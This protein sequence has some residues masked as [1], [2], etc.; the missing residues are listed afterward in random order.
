MPELTGEPFTREKL[1]RLLRPRSVAIVG[2]SDKRGSFGASVLENLDSTGFAGQIYLVNPNRARI[3]ERSCFSAVDDLPDGVDCAVLAIPRAGILEAVRACARKRIG[4]VVIFSAGFAESGEVGKRDQDEL[5]AIARSSGMVIQGP[6]CLG[7]V[8]SRDGLAL[9]FVTTPKP[10]PLG[11]RGVAVVSQSGAMACVLGVAFRTHSAEVTY[12]I[13]TGN[14]AVSGVEDYVEYLLSDESTSVI[15]LLVEQFRNPRRFLSLA[16]RAAR[17]GKRLVLLHPG[18]SSAAR[19]SAATH[20]GAIAG[21]YAVMRAKVAHAG[22]VLVDTLEE[23]AD[24]ASLLL[25]CDTVPTAGT[26]VLT[27]SGAFKALTLDLCERVG[28]PLPQLSTTTCAGLRQALPD[29]VQ[30]T[31]PLDITAQG[32]ADPGLYR[33]TLPPLLDDESIGSVL[34]TIILTDEST[35]ELKLPPILDAI[36]ALSEAPSKRWGKLIVFAA[37]DEGAFINPAYKTR[38]LNLGVPFFPT[39]ERALRALARLAAAAS[40]RSSSGVHDHPPPAPALTGGILPEHRSKQLLALAGIPTPPGR[41]V[42]TLPEAAEC[43]RVIGYPVVLKAQSSQLSHKSDAGGVV[44]SLLDAQELAAGWQRLQE[45][46]ASAAP[47]LILDGVLV[48]T[49][50]KPGTELI[51]GAR[52]DP[53]W[54]PVVLVGL[55]G[56]FAEAFQDVRLLVPGISEAEIV[57]EMSRLKGA[58]LLGGFRGAPAVDGAAV[59]AIVYR[60]GTFML[61]HPEIQEIDINPVIACR[62]GQGALALDALIVTA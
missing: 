50:S 36:A 29:F 51:V 3:G 49:M 7:L 39:A 10:Q 54:G 35:G 19:V 8:N 31:N 15:A 2:A 20:T 48:E 11:S 47:G 23:L 4:G 26:A 46:V 21:D 44:L 41:L 56:V 38:L 30:P 33:R 9:T 61:S 17:A 55:G 27:E 12:S 34:L 6:N 57:N 59:A 25:H 18:S 24:V 52:N 40:T 62:A 28:L 16:E 13:S 60:L 37:L 22:V 1:D 14:E 43:A 53:Q 45:N 32:L 42:Q 5:A 58:A